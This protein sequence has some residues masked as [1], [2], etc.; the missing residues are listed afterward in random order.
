L[1]EHTR[2]RHPDHL[3]ADVYV[4]PTVTL[5][6]SETTTSRLEELRRRGI[7]RTV[8]VE[9]I[10]DRVTLDPGSHPDGF[11]AVLTRFER[12]ARATDVTL[13][14]SFSVTAATSTLWGKTRRQLHLPMICLC[15]RRGA[16]VVGVFPHSTPT[17]HRT[18]ED[19]LDGL[20]AGRLDTILPNLTAALSVPSDACPECGGTLVNLQGV[21]ACYDCHWD[22]LAA[23]TDE[24]QPSA[25]PHAPT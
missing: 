5:E 17:A 10:P 20:A 13:G 9:S 3:S 8:T 12:W 4:R 2:I 14:P 11:V 19:A 1:T 23:R 21:L 16:T 22:E 25:E 18:V 24:P 7:L 15:L 6:T